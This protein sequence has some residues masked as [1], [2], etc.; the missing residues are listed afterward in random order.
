MARED[1]IRLIA[2]NIWEQESCPHGK[3]C[4]HWFRAEVIWEEQQKP[5]AVATNPRTPPKQIVQKSK[6][7]KAA[8]PKKS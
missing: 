5:K 7:K 2:Y 4:E 1:E 8:K 6:K 3:D